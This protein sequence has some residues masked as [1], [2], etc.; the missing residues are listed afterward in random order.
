MKSI[1]LF[2]LPYAGGTRY[3]YRKYEEIAPKFIRVVVLEYP[4]RGSRIREPLMTDIGELVEDAFRQVSDMVGGEA[5]SIY[6]HSM[7]G[8]VGCLLTRKLAA[9]SY[10][11]PLHLFIT[12]TSGPS[13]E[14]R[15]ESRHLLE[16][17]EFLEEIRKFDGCPKEFFEDEEMVDFFEPIIR[18]DFQASETYVHSGAEP[19][20]VPIT[21]I[22]GSEEDMEIE[23]IKAWQQETRQTVDFK[24]L[25]GNHFFIFQHSFTVMEIISKKLFVHI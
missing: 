3:S 5:Y 13:A 19:M 4:G 10:K 20:N 14:R 12:G 1:T 6:G 16:K 7:G 24:C 15:K 17:V 22:T 2:C 23:D 25:P 11:P 21:V 8:L 18:A 9:E